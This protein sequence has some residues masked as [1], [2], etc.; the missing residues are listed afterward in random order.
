[1]F[2][3]RVWKAEPI[4]G[5]DF[6]GLKLTYRS[7]DGEEGYPGNLDCIVNY[8]LNNKNEWKMEYTAQTDKPTVVNFAN[9]SYWKLGGAHS[10]T[11]LDEI[12]TVKAD[13]YLLADDALIPT[14]EI[15]PVDG[16]PVDFRTPHRVGERMRDIKEKQFGGGY[17]HCLVLHH[18]KPGDLVFCA[19][20]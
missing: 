19:K 12:L 14:G 7:K 1:G 18:E 10:G 17:D 15:V 13:R 8:E 9:H 20:V 5:G 6:V 16:T 3:K 4:R 11:V 2:N